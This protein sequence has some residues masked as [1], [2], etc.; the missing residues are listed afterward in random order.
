MS[1]NFL[2]RTARDECN[3]AAKIYMS[4]ASALTE[5]FGYGKMLRENA[6]SVCLKITV[7]TV[8]DGEEESITVRCREKTEELMMLVNALGAAVEGV[9]G[10]RGDEM[11]KIKLADIY[12]FEV[13][14]NKAFIY[15]EREVYESKLKLYEFESLTRGTRFFRAT[16]STVVNADK[17]KSVSP[18]LSGR[19][20]VKLVN[21]E[22][23]VVS[24]GYV[25]ALKKVLGL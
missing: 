22:S 16:K 8:A 17:I 23:T 14:E 12:Y 2:S 25:S 11:F 7:D 15:C 1:V 4:L 21:G 5:P 20:N 18:S 13:L 10:C 6:R 24:R 9:T 19:F 3:S